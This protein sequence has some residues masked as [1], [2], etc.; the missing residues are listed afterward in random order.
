MIDSLREVMVEHRPH[1]VDVV[2]HEQLHEDPHP[3][4]DSDTRDQ[5]A[6]PGPGPRA[7]AAGASVAGM[8]I[9]PLR[10]RRDERLPVLPRQPVSREF[11]FER[12]RPVDR[13]YIERFLQE[14]SA[15]IR[16]RVLEV[17][18]DSYTRLYGDGQV[19]QSDV[20]HAAAD[21]PDATIAGD[22]VSG[23]GIPEAAFDCFI[24]TQTLQFIPDAPAAVA[25]MRRLLAPGGVLLAT[26]PGISQISRVDDAA[27]GDWWRFTQRGTQRLFAQAFGE[28][29]VD[30][31][32]HGNVQSAAA[33]LYGLA[34]EDLETQDLARDDPAFHLLI[35]VRAV[36]QND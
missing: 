9:R 25:G 12:G 21:D 36:R 14:H 26:V 29:N 30:V 23:A 6:D 19:T 35:T 5:R 31:R 28:A 10:R 2:A 34:A 16:G 18:E 8:P 32:R 13:W 4:A 3:A 11:G 24:C 20:L 33:F 27:W 7:A 22:L 17:A 1:D 15:D